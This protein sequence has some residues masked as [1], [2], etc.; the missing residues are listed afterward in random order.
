MIRTGVIRNPRSRRNHRR[1]PPPPAPDGVLSAAPATRKALDE[2]LARFAAEGL[3]LLV[4][5]GGDGTVRDVLSR[6]PA[7]FRQGLPPLA[8]LPSGKTN[9][10]ALDLGAPRG[11][12]LEAAIEAASRGRFS[13]RAPLEVTRLGAADPL[14]RG[15]IFGAG[16]YVRATELAQ[17]THQL[18]VFDSLAV[19]LTLGVAAVETLAGGS[20]NRWRAGVPM[21]LRCENEPDEP[22]PV[23]LLLAS[24]LERLPLDL[25]PV[26]PPSP[27]FKILTV[28][29]PPRQLLRAL[30]PLLAGGEPGW[31]EAAGYRR[32]L[33]GALEVQLESRFVLDGEAFTGGQLRVAEGAPLAFVTP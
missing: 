25:K 13:R 31:L 7:H 16:I 15:F 14:A 5:D 21:R 3:D 27:G 22:R 12:T 18:G 33:A 1:G 24:S 29:A 4:I 9:A 2:A 30:P 6:A 11:W 8:V 28:E 19:A 20:R 23:F 17:R 10:L 26:G 32:R